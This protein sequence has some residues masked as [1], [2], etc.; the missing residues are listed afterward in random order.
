MYQ[1]VLQDRPV[2]LRILKKIGRGNLGSPKIRIQGVKL[3]IHPRKQ[4]F[5]WDFRDSAARGD[6]D[7]E[8]GHATVALQ[9]V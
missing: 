1:A 9:V 7:S 8:R 4:G 2:H 5:L 6:L 3:W